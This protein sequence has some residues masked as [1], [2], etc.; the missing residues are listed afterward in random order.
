MTNTA[1]DLPA[2]SAVGGLYS[3]VVIHA[4]IAYVSGQLPR[5][6]GELQFS[7]KVGRD[8]D[9]AGAC[10]AA[11]LCALQ[12]LATLEMAL[13]NLDRVERLLKVTGYVVCDNDF[14]QQPA[15]IDAASALFQEKL[16]ERGSHARSAVGVSS[17]PRGACVEVEIMA[18]VRA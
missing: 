3:A 14:T 16:G 2:P 17:L 7:G 15:V 12:C 18:A 1:K 6:N 13:G 4:G 10:E 8:I 5:L 9:L 11:Q